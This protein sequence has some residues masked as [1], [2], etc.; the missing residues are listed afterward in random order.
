M[1]TGG[2]NALKSPALFLKVFQVTHDKTVINSLNFH[3]FFLSRAISS[4]IYQRIPFKNLR[5][6]SLSL[7]SQSCVL[8]LSNKFLLMG[9]CLNPFSIGDLLVRRILYCLS[10]EMVTKSYLF[11]RRRLA[12]LLIMPKPLKKQILLERLSWNSCVAILS[13]K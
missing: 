13:R 5:A 2:P 9:N 6:L 3:H 12:V 4:K 8:L 10:S 1:A 11:Q 7:R